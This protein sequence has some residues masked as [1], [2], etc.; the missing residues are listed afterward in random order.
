MVW[1]IDKV[2]ASECSTKHVYEEGPKN[3]SLSVVSGINIECYSCPRLLY[4]FIFSILSMIKL[5]IN[6]MFSRAS[7]FA[8]GQTSRRKTYTMCGINEYTM[9]DI[10][11][12]IHV[13]LIY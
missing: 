4:H 13:V 6:L 12:Y 11:N 7:I 2:F 5:D 10:F 8:Y 3:V 9:S 1:R